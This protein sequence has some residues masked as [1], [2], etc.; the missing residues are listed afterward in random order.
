M[1]GIGF[2]TVVGAEVMHDNVL[3]NANMLQASMENGVKRFFF[4]PPPAC[5]LPT[6]RQSAEVDPSKR[7]MPIRSIRIISTAGKS[8]IPR[9]CVKHTREITDLK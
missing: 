6:D 9:R 3:I 5:I 1:G 4:P 7:K 2:I 8:F